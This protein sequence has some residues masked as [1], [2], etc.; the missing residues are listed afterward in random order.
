[1]L[2]GTETRVPVISVLA[3]DSEVVSRAI[4]HKYVGQD[5]Q[6]RALEYLGKILQ[7][8][9]GL[10]EPDEAK[11]RRLLQTVVPAKAGGLPDSEEKGADEKRGGQV[12]SDSDAIDIAIMDN[13]PLLG[14]EAEERMS[15]QLMSQYFT[16]NTRKARLPSPVQTALPAPSRTAFARRFP[17]DWLCELIS[18]AA[19]QE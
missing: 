4:A 6:L 15:F 18:T 8:S 12:P 3:V 5:A 11:R 14:F 17:P 13:D 2:L 9:I 16:P 7:L 1:M 19:H 10:P